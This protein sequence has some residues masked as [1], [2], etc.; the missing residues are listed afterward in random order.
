MG[1]SRSPCLRAALDAN[2]VDFWA[3]CHCSPASEVTHPA[4][5]AP[6]W[7]R[8]SSASSSLAAATPGGWWHMPWASSA[9][10]SPHAS[11]ALEKV[12]VWWWD[13]REFEHCGMLIPP[14]FLWAPLFNCEKFVTGARQSRAGSPALLWVSASETRRKSSEVSPMF[15]NTIWCKLSSKLFKITSRLRCLP[16]SARMP[17]PQPRRSPV[18]RSSRHAAPAHL[19]GFP[20][21]SPAPAGRA[22][23]QSRGQARCQGSVCGT[24]LSLEPEHPPRA[25]KRPGS[26]STTAC[27][28]RN[29][30][31]EAPLSSLEGLPTLDVP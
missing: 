29:S 8:A 9:S 28:G 15:I 23:M 18:V 31:F 10:G 20:S 11:A 19:R 7:G 25:P 30:A 13:R 24:T 5:P 2:P 6:E 27:R 14:R 21:S 26:H 16:R 22:G 4:C 1:A 17:S 3:R 12:R